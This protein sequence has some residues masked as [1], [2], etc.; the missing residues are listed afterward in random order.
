MASELFDDH[1]CKVSAIDQKQTILSA[2]NMDE[3]TGVS[4]DFLCNG[5]YQLYAEY[6]DEITYMEHLDLAAD[7]ALRTETVSYLDGYDR[8]GG[9][10]YD[11]VYGNSQRTAV[12]GR[13]V[14]G[15]SSNVF[16]VISEVK[17][18]D[19]VSSAWQPS[20]EVRPQDDDWALNIEN[21]L[22]ELECPSE[23]PTAAVLPDKTFY[24]NDSCN[25]FL[26]ES[27]DSLYT[28]LQTLDTTDAPLLVYTDNEIISNTLD[29]IDIPTTVTP[30]S[31]DDSLDRN[32]YICTYLNCQKVYAKP[33]HLKAHLRRHAGDKPYICTWPACT[34]R[35]SRSD[36]LSRHRRSHSG[37]K[38]YKCNYCPKCFSR[39]D[40]LTKHR[41]VHERKLAKQRGTWQ[42]TAIHRLPHVKPGRRP[43]H[44]EHSRPHS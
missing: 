32:S 29:T 6:D 9:E 23:W 11:I 8:C 22:L 44:T 13:E 4:E 16:S 43:K 24:C 35:F 40:H 42:G 39:S 14:C 20:K 12:S 33:A 2:R 5:F 21:M 30:T 31:I 28:T 3:L 37:V 36:E 18:H 17:V 41:K 26:R 38:P 15:S 34:W 10:S 1:L 27:S 7:C 19:R 25:V